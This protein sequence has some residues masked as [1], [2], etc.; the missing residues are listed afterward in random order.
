MADQEQSPAETPPPKKR[1]LFAALL[2]GSLGLVLGAGGFAIP[3]FLS[4]LMG[5]AAEG[6]SSSTSQIKPA[7]ITFGA[8]VVNLNSDRFN[9]YLR[10]SITLQVAES[11]VEAVNELIDK[12]KSV[13]KSWLL[14]HL[15]DK[16]MQEIR[17]AAG[18]NRLRR[19]IQDQFNTI[20]FPDGYDRIHDV[21]FEEFNVQ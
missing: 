2:W 14:S 8:A 18:Q 4:G 6:T 7:F 5:S 9:R 3:L 21:L 13:L 17:G 19:E 20:L 12:Q 1:R 16:T 15:S 10:M 11:D